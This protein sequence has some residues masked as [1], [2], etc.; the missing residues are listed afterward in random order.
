MDE[1][2]NSQNN[3]E[4][5]IDDSENESSELTLEQ[6]QEKNRHLFARTKKAEGKVKEFEKQL[7]EMKSQVDS[8]NEPKA[9]K[10]EKP[11]DKLLERLDR[12]A[13]QVAGIKEADE[14]ELFG[15]W[16]DQTGREADDIVGNSIFKKELE[17][18]RTS[19]ANQAASSNIAGETGASGAR[20]TPEY[21][22]AKATKDDK[23][24]L[25]FPDDM[26][27]EL[28]V[29]VLDLVAKESGE[30]S[31]ELKFYNK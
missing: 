23:G 27:K 18:L 14:V 1:N 12:M 7:K 21:W 6:L 4:S 25:L 17:E 28:Y 19:K 26:P 2:I 13:L 9:K 20:N 31:E 30:T 8:L 15:K 16:K 10:A 5:D 22:R 29:K 11:D 24:Q 3:A